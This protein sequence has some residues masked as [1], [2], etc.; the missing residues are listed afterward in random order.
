MAY[1]IMG[2]IA[3]GQVAAGGVGS[4]EPSVA[5]MQTPVGMAGSGQALAGLGFTPGV[6]AG[7][8]LGAGAGV[9]VGQQFPMPAAIPNLAPALGALG[10]AFPALASLT[11]ALAP[12]AAGAA[13]IYGL[14]QLLGLGEGGGLFGT[15]LLG[16]DVSSIG[17]IQLG[18]PG[19]A[20]PDARYVIKEWARDTAA[21]RVQ[22][23]RVQ[24]PGMK[25]PV[26]VGYY[27]NFKRWV[28]FKA[29]HLAVIGKKLP[30]HKQLTRLK[31]NLVRHAAD[32]R[33]ILKI[34]SP[35]SLAS[36]GGDHRR[37]R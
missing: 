29:P 15:N 12:V 3:A 20:E 28:Q 31:R 37:R 36:S 18:G 1:D 5:I 22:Y 17:R 26:T 32:A 10:V 19:L 8:G 34:T 27:V 16:G 30:S 33:T 4:A 24:Q 21:G 14:L 23:Y 13:G 2:A 9:V 25:K 35:A 6:L 11:G 7:V